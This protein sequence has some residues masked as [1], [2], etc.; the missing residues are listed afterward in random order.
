MARSMQYVTLLGKACTHPNLLYFDH[1]DTTAKAAAPPPIPPS[2]WPAHFNPLDESALWEWSGK[3]RV[4]HRL[5]ASLRP[6]R[7]VLA[8]N[9]ARTLDL[10]Q[11][12]CEQNQWP[13]LRLDGQTP[14][15]DRLGLVEQ[16]NAPRAARDSGQQPWV[17]LLSSKAGGTGLNLVGAGR[18]ILFDPSWNPAID[19]QV[20]ARIWRPGT[21]AQRVVTYR[22]LTT[23]SLEEKVYQRQLLKGDYSCGAVDG[24][25]D[26][27][28]YYTSDELAQV[29]EFDGSTFSSTYE[30]QGF[31]Q[32]LC[33]DEDPHLSAAVGTGW[34]SHVH[35]QGKEAAAARG[36]APLQEVHA[37][38]LLLSSTTYDS[39]PT[40]CTCTCTYLCYSLLTSY[41]LAAMP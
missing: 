6:Q 3:M 4:C 32:N 38:L 36:E 12:M 2:V 11:V 9:H 16:F 25:A 27:H 20:L 26:A 28:R 39:L 10:L 21:T 34:V 40:T 8:S 18:L 15:K 33:C 7:V 5:L 22:L 19:E 35:E 29:F 23:G 13:T 31:E 24:A 41:R 37:A 17:F 1:R 30:L 14:A